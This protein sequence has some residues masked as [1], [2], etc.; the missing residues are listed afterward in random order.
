MAKYHISTD[1]SGDLGWKFDQ[2]YRYGGSSRYITIASIVLAEGNHHKAA[3]LVRKLKKKFDIP[4][5]QEV[6]WAKMSPNMRK[7]FAVM[8]RTLAQ[9]NSN[10]QFH[11]ITVYKQNVAPHIREDQNKLYNYM[12][13][14]SLAPVMAEVDD[15][16]FVPDPRSIKVGSGNSLHDYLVSTLWFDL[17]TK[18]N[19]ITR[20]KDSK[21]DLSVQFADMLAG[22]IQSHFE[23]RKSGAWDILSANI[24]WKSLYFPT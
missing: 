20:P 9:S 19:L 11:A 13:K 5:G 17:G 14:L 21:A 7:A 1:E 22:L 24:R 3:R 15:V 23:D 18:T 4:A 2:P 8:A 12:I 16:L 10:I 6:K